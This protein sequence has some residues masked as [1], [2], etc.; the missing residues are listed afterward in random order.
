M[1]PSVRSLLRRARYLSAP[2]N[3]DIPARVLVSLLVLVS[4]ALPPD[5]YSSTTI[6]TISFTYLALLSAKSEFPAFSPDQIDPAGGEG[7]FDSPGAGIN[8]SFFTALRFEEHPAKTK[9]SNPT[10]KTAD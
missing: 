2:K 7:I 6:V 3:A 8:S 9:R 4:A 1:S 10:N 5:E